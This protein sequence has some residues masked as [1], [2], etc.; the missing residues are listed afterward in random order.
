MN[1]QLTESNWE[2]S[3]E[4]VIDNCESKFNELSGL[5]CEPNEMLDDYSKY[6]KDAKKKYQSYKSSPFKD[7]KK[8]IGEDLS[9]FQQQCNAYYT[10]LKDN[11]TKKCKRGIRLF[12]N[13]KNYFMLALFLISIIFIIIGALV[14][15]KA[16][17]GILLTFG[18]LMLLIVIGN[19]VYKFLKQRGII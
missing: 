16:A 13:N 12:K 4:G 18:I 17:K 1:Q 5:A 15:N 14:E 8:S 7:S 2:Q 6:S 11:I 10:P 3:F 19:F 9:F